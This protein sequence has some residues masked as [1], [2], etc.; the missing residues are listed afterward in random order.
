M[1]KTFL[2]QTLHQKNKLHALYFL[3]ILASHGYDLLTR[4]ELSDV[5]RT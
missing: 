1:H 2:S 4:Q 5:A 3:A